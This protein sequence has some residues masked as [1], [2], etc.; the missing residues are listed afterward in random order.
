M[1]RQGCIIRAAINQRSSG[2]NE[3][4]RGVGLIQTYLD[5][6]EEKNGFSRKEARLWI[7]E[8]TGKNYSNSR[9]YEFIHNKRAATDQLLE[10]INTDMK[11]L[12]HWL[13]DE[14]KLDIG[15]LAEALLLPVKQP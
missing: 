9:L 15:E 3:L 2:V 7:C 11:G 1:A 13:I 10:L 5:Y 14:K 12:L 8:Q 6:I 4:S